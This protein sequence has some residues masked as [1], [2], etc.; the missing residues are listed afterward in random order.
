MGRV[1]R[2]ARPD[3]AV[4]VDAGRAVLWRRGVHGNGHAWHRLRGVAN[5]WHGDMEQLYAGV[6][7]TDAASG[8]GS[9]RPTAAGLRRRPHLLIA[10]GAENV[11]SAAPTTWARARR[12][13]AA[14]LKATWR[15]SRAGFLAEAQRRRPHRHTAQGIRRRMA[16]RR[17]PAARWHVRARAAI[18]HRD[19]RRTERVQRGARWHPLAS[20]PNAWLQ[21]EAV[22]ERKSNVDADGWYVSLNF[23]ALDTPWKPLVTAR[24]ASFSGD[25]A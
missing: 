22:W 5:T 8:L 6:R 11:P 23:H 4:S 20:A 9:T 3:R 12:A 25:I 18:G 10:S 1:L 14:L 24:Y 13:N 16:Q 17:G 15:I 19:A 7:W 21:G 2:R